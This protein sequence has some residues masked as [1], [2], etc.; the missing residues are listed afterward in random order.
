ML[1]TRLTDDR[2]ARGVPLA[3]PMTDDEKNRNAL[4][5]YQ[6]PLKQKKITYNENELLDNTMVGGNY[7]SVSAYN[8]LG[9]KKGGNFNEVKQSDYV[10]ECDDYSQKKSKK[11]LKMSDTLGNTRGFE[12][13]VLS[14]GRIM[15]KF[16]GT[17]NLK[18]VRD[19]RYPIRCVYQSY[20]VTDNTTIT[21]TQIKDISDNINTIYTK[22]FASGSLVLNTTERKTEPIFNTTSGVQNKLC[23]FM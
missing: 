8:S 22:G 6:I 18:L 20:N 15:G 13:A 11:T 5:I 10:L 23:S 21:E 2:K 17:N 9:I 1:A 14:K 3:G 7:G 4:F 12:K 16:T 19:T